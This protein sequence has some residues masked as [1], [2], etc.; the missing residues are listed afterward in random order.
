MMRYQDSS[1][2]SAENCV[3]DIVSRV[4]AKLRKR[5]P[6]MYATQMGKA[7]IGPVPLDTGIHRSPA[8]LQA[9]GQILE[10]QGKEPR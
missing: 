3:T 10:I 7:P 9:K 8:A 2:L 4:S 6:G 5:V 1:V